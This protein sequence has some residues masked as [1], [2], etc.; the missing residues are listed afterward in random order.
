VLR[1]LLKVGKFLLGFTG[2]VV[3]VL[4]EGLAATGRS[5]DESTLTDGSGLMGE[6]NLRTGRLDAGLDPH[7]WY[8]DD[9]DERP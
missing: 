6:Y 1:T 8:E 4:G 5:N 3:G 9:P 7:G 2:K